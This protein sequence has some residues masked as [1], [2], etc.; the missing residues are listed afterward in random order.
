MVVI[1][2]FYLTC[3]EVP[4]GYSSAVLG[5]IFVYNL[6]LMISLY[7]TYSYPL[8]TDEEIEALSHCPEP[9]SE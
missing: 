3:K 2:V 8:F 9:Q 6:I 1:L 5:T 7:V 4:R